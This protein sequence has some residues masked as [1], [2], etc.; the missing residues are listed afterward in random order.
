MN[1]DFGHNGTY[2]RTQLHP[3]HNVFHSYGDHGRSSM[4]IQ[5]RRIAV[6]YSDASDNIVESTLEVSAL[7]V[8]VSQ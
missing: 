7:F 3:L 1:V 5:H 8:G 6:S 4:M 2:A